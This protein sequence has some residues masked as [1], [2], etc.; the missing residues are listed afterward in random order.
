VHRN[1]SDSGRA[2]VKDGQ[3]RWSKTEQSEEGDRTGKGMAV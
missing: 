1:S 3:H 2:H